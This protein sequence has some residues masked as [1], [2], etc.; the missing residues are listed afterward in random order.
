MEGAAAENWQSRVV[1]STSLPLW[2]LA[3]ENLNISAHLTPCDYDQQIKITIFRYIPW[4]CNGFLTCQV[5]NSKIETRDVSSIAS[6]QKDA[7]K[8][9]NIFRSNIQKSLK[10]SNRRTRTIELQQECRIRK[11]TTFWSCCACTNGKWNTQSF[12]R[13]WDSENRSEL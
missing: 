5:H 13:N 12:A 11:S 10:P 4:H 8:S 3:S 7:T 6:N 9:K 2:R 1:L